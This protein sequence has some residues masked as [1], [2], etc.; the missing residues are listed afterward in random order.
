MLTITGNAILGMSSTDTVMGLTT[1][2]VTGTTKINTTN[3]TSSGTQM[4]DGAVTL[5]SCSAGAGTGDIDFVSTIDGAFSLTANSTGT[6]TF[7]GLVGSST[8]LTALTTNAGGITHIH[9][10]MTTTSTQIYNDAV[11]LDTNTTLSG[12]TVTTLTC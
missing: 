4:Y 8:A 2:L 10:G 12:S 6:T 1:L 9:G 11:L 5:S 7:G 3:I